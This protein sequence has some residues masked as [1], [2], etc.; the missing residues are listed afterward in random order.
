MHLYNYHPES[1]E[2]LGQITAD[3]S[4]LEEDV[5]LMPAATTTTPPPISTRQAGQGLRYDLQ[6]DTWQIV[7]DYRGETWYSTT[8]GSACVIDTLGMP[9]DSLT[10]QPRPSVFYFW[11]DGAWHA[12][13][14]LIAYSASA[15]D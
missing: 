12:D 13:I 2:Y 11:C 3:A 15:R 6:L 14:R 8:D 7:P 5:Y 1:H 9:A 4:P 10:P